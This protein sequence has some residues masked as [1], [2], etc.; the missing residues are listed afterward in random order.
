MTQRSG[1]FNKT[2]TGDAIAHAA[3]IDALLINAMYR[4]PLETN[5]KARG[6]F[7][8]T[9]ASATTDPLNVTQS[10]VPAMTVQVNVGAALLDGHWYHNDAAET[11][12]IANNSTGATRY[13]SVVLQFVAATPSIRLVVKTGT[14]SPPTLTDTIAYSLT[15]AVTGVLEWE[16]A[17]ITV[18]NAAS[19]IVNANINTSYNIPLQSSLYQVK[20]TASS[21]APSTFA[22]LWGSLQQRKA[23]PLL[24]VKYTDQSAIFFSTDQGTNWLELKN[25]LNIPSASLNNG[26]GS[27]T[28]S[29]SEVTVVSTS[30]T[31]TGRS[32]VL[33]TWFIDFY[34]TVSG[35]TTIRFKHGSTTIVTY[36]IPDLV[37][38]Q[39]AQSCIIAAPAAGSLTASITIQKTTANGVFSYNLANITIAELG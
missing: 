17:R 16:I 9:G 1:W 3:Q 13:D 18:A 5:N 8:L 20:T 23:T 22:A 7:P 29:T 24:V 28:P 35:T 34:N 32:K 26:S 37:Q 36:V 15:S 27:V 38:L 39:F 25:G 30:I 33:I 19:S 10:T 2:N 21:N 31:A 12:S 6:H 4:N 11:L 14:A